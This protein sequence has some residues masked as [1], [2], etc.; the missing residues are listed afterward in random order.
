MCACVSV[1]VCQLDEL[2]MKDHQY[3]D[4]GVGLQVKLMQGNCSTT[5]D[6]AAAA[7]AATAGPSLSAMSD[8]TS[9]HVDL[10]QVNKLPTAGIVFLFLGGAFSYRPNTKAVRTSAIQLRYKKKHSCIAVV[11]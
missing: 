5:K 2:K 8:N 3:P 7:G 1:C 10:S 9:K 6:Q 4:R 11:L